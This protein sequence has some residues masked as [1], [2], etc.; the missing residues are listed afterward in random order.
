MMN[1]I[2]LFLPDL[3]GGG[4]QRVMVN[5]AVGLVGRGFAVDL[6]LIRSE[7]QYLN[8][9]PD[10]VRIVELA[11]R[12]VLASILPL[13]HYLR[14][15][16]PL[17]IVSALDYANIS[18][19]WAKKIAAIPGR[20]IVVNH[21]NLAVATL[22]SSQ[23][24]S[25][26]MPLCIRLSYPRADAIVSVSRGA[27]AALEKTAHLPP[28]TVRVVYN[29]VISDQIHAM[30]QDLPDHPWFYESDIPVVLSVGSL[31]VVKN[32]VSLLRAFAHVRKERHSR[33]VILGEGDQRSALQGL[34]TDLGVAEDFSLPGF[35]PN[36]YA[37]LSRSTVFVLSS[38]W[39]ALPTVIIEALACGTKVVAID[40]ESGPRE[41][42]GGG[43]LGMLVPPGDDSA[44]ANV[45]LE[46]MDMPLRK[47]SETDL[48][49]Y[50]VETAVNSYLGLLGLA[51]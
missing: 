42:L 49:P 15:E 3:S 8:Q 47:I 23:W 51:V 31:T 26:M 18:A 37:Y 21:T 14:R 36:P 24:R 48:Q 39:E 25:K 10:G 40:C 30:A 7:G 28:G 33:L 44:L 12:R 9:V 22:H 45:I 35:K 46:S 16:R 6:V 43:R 5:L 4:A 50:A 34:A 19:I 11:S 17:G 41:L 13:V 2:A 1:P 32:H 38:L 20:L 29:P 27:A